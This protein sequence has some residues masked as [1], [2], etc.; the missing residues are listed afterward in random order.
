MREGADVAR[1]TI[2][3]G[4]DTKAD[5]DRSCVE[6]VSR[7]Y[8]GRLM[9][10][11]VTP[12]ARDDASRRHSRSGKRSISLT[13]LVT[14]TLLDTEERIR[15]FLPEVHEVLGDAPMRL[16][17]ARGLIPLSRQPADS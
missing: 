8:A 3:I 16:E 2:E 14:V 5:A 6:L 10:V 1:L 17:T 13:C 7:A 11:T 15:A 4:A 9:G 12:G